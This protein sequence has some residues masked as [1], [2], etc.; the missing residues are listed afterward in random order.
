MKNKFENADKVFAMKNVC[1]NKA[2]EQS[3]KF[4][5]KYDKIFEQSIHSSYA[6]NL[7]KSEAADEEQIRKCRQGICNEKC[8]FEQ[9]IRTKHKISNKV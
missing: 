2:F 4:R 3:I 6:C 8:V 9:G 1:S 7:G 5:T